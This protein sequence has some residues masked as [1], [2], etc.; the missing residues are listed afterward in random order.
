MTLTT[1]TEKIT[2]ATRAVEL[3]GYREDAD[4]LPPPERAAA[5]RQIQEKFEALRGGN[6]RQMFVPEKT[7]TI[8]NLFGKHPQV[9]AATDPDYGNPVSPCAGEPPSRPHPKP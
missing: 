4:Q 8:K 9:S 2:A 7:K 5:L 3:I 1:L 6:R